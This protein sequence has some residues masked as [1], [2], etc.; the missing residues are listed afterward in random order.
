MQNVDGCA[1]H[2]L[3]EYIKR[4]CGLAMNESN[5]YRYVSNSENNDEGNL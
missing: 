5:L 2:K 4:D 1:Y 3:S